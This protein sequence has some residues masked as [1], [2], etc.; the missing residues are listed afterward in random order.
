MRAFPVAAQ[1]SRADSPDSERAVISAP[2]ET[3]EVTSSKFSALQASKI[4]AVEDIVPEN[5]RTVQ[6]Y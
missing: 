1:T 2:E 4:L 6:M 3:C 5:G